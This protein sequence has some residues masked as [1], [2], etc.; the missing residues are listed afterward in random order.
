MW[1]PSLAAPADPA[2]APTT[3][4]VPP[5]WVMIKIQMPKPAFAGTPKQVPPNTT[6]D[7]K[8]P[9]SWP[10]A[11]PEGAKNLALKKPVTSSDEN[12]IIGNLSL[13]TDGDKE[14]TDG[15]WVELAPMVQWVQI[16]LKEEAAIYGIV[17]WHYHGEARVFRDVVV[18]VSN[19][20]DFITGV[21]T[22]F[23][24][25]QDNSAGLG[26]GDE[27]EYFELADGKLVEAKGAQARYVRLYSN[28]STSDTQNL[29]TEVEVWGVPAKEAK[30]AAK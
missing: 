16:D 29:Y 12:P 11:A 15:S 27:R 1:G 9:P 8:A 14:A 18:Q 28:G 3:R 26:K 19:D 22:L 30:A 6:V 13:V 20:R 23:N 5:G 2:P 10:F 24:N 7:P 25:D 21:T 4:P 17:F